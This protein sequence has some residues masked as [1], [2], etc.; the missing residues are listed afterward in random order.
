MCSSIHSLANDVFAITQSAFLVA[1][2]H[3]SFAVTLHVFV[4]QAPGSE[5]DE[6]RNRGR[7]KK[8]R[9]QLGK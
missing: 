4:A 6:K 5:N 1:S 3:F 9:K 8:C 7:K 2:L